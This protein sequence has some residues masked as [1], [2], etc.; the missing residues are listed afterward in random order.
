M[1]RYR[2]AGR[3]RRFFDH[4]LRRDPSNA[5]LWILAIASE[6]LQPITTDIHRVRTLFERATEEAKVGYC[7]IEVI[8][9]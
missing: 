9:D 4:Q 5:M 6:L 2:I 7:G 1:Y 8:F 3:V